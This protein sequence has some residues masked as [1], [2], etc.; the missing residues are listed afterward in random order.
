MQSLCAELRKFPAGEM[1]QIIQRNKPNNTFPL[2][3]SPSN[4]QNSLFCFMP[5]CAE[6]GTRDNCFDRFMANIVT[7]HMS[8]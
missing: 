2:P 1:Y 8:H 4:S 7:C 6:L 3:P 5:I